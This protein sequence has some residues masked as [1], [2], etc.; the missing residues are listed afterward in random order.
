MLSKKEKTILI[1]IQAF[2]WCAY[3]IVMV[4]YFGGKTNDYNFAVKS[5]SLALGSYIM[6]VY[7]HAF[8]LWKRFYKRKKYARYALLCL[9]LLCAV[10]FLRIYAEK[11]LFYDAVR[12]FYKGA[13]PHVSITFITISLAL[14]FGIFICIATDYFMLYKHTT[15]L[16]RQQAIT[17]LQL[18]KNQVQPHFLFNTLNNIYALAHAKSDDT[19]IAIGKLASMMRYF[20]EDASKEKIALEKE[21]DFIENYIALEQIRMTSPV[22]IT[23]QVTLTEVQLPPM[24]LIPFIENVFKHGVDKTL[25]DNEMSIVLKTTATALVYEVKNRLQPGM[26]QEKGTGNGLDNLHKRLQL[27]YGTDFIFTT[28][29]AN[30]WFEAALHIPI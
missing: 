13:G 30:G 3:G 22:I 28:G 21:W 11:W 10:A 6:A 24:L 1:T 15:A 8:A 14:V 29:P 16:Q 23:R 25:A 5:V 2:L 17:E 19:T 7:I 26:Q 12:T 9:V 18:L 27:L 20:T 4:L